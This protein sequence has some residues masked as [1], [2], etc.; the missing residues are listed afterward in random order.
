MH[1]FDY[2]IPQ[3]FTSVWGLRMVVTLGIVSEVL[4]VPRVAHFDYPSFEL[5]RTVS[6][7]ELESLFYETPSS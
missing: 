4:Y 1:G 5:L 6:K 7:D 2:F 3:F